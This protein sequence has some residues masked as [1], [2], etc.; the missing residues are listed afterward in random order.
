M[1]CESHRCLMANVL[2]YNIPVNDFELQWHFYAYFRTNT[3]EKCMNSGLLPI[4]G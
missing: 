1:V 4:M 3:L 2:D